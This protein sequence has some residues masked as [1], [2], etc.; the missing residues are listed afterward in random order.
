MIKQLFFT[1]AL[2]APS[3]TYAGNPSA[4]LPGQIVPAGTIPAP[5]QAAGFTTLAFSADEATVSV[6]S[7][8][9]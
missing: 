2:L 3:L 4:T 1:A 5:A 6:E 9:C 8:Y 7:T